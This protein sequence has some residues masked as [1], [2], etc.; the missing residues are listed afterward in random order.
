MA[1]LP[2]TARVVIIGGGAVGA[3]CLYHLAL[4]GWTDCVLLE[5]NEL[6]SGSTWHAAGNVPT[7]SSSWGIMNIQRY[8]AEL[9]RGLADAVDYPMNYHVTG[10]VRLAHSKERMQEFQRV[11][12]MGRYQGMDLEVCTPDELKAHYPYLE[13]HDLAGG[14]YDPYDGD[15]DPG[16][17]D[18]GPG[19][20]RARQ[21][22]EDRALLRG[23]R[24]APRG[25]R[26]GGRDREGRDPL[27]IRGER[28]RLS[29]ARGGRLVR[30]QGADG[31]HEPPIHP[32]RGGGG[33]RPAHG[34]DGAASCRSCAMSTAPTTCARRRTA[35]IWGLTSGTAARIG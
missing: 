25:R 32:V 21:G 6:T 22:A 35:S 18:P 12:G 4:K 27:R 26:V 8:S 9:Y 13:T 28:R 14:L 5:K 2:S 34:G 19:Q 1:D 31:D 30:P 33:A 29:R 11:K 17:A 23:D 24:R 15:I 3:S 16:A 20:G 7:F 10:S